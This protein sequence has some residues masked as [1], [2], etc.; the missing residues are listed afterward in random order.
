MEYPKMIS[1]YFIQLIYQSIPLFYL[2][3]SPFFKE[4]KVLELKRNQRLGL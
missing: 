4:I 1:Q 3:L 2:T